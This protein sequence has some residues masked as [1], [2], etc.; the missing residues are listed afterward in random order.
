MDHSTLD[1]FSQLSGLLYFVV[2]FAGVLIYVM[3]PSNKKTFDS[4][5][6]LPLDGDA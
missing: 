2:I 5:A 1:Q 4:A 6:N 3:R